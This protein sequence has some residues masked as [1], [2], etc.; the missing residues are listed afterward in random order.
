MIEIDLGVSASGTAQKQD[1]TVLTALP[2]GT[3]VT[4]M[5]TLNSSQSLAST[6][7][8]LTVA[9]DGTISGN[10]DR[11]TNASFGSSTI[12]SGNL[13]FPDPSFGR[14][15]GTLSD[16]VAGAS[17]FSY[18]VV[19]ST[20]LILFSMDAGKLGV[21]QAEKQSGG[22]FNAASFT[23]PYAFASVGDTTVSE[24]TNSAGRFDADGSGAIN[25][26]VLDAV[27][28]GTVA[29]VN[30]TGTYTAATNGRV[31]VSLT[32]GS[33]SI[34]QVYWMVSPS[35]AF[36]ITNSPTSIEDGSV[37]KQVGT[38]ST[39]TLN[40]IYAFG[41]T[42]FDG[43]LTNDLTGTLTGNGSGTLNMVLLPNVNGQIPAQNQTQ[44]FSGTYTVSNNGRVV[45]SLNNFSSNLIMY[46]VSSSQA[47]IIQT[48]S[49]VELHGAMTLQ[50]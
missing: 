26:G 48:D 16:S 15:S 49:N 36:T 6:I 22:P 32:E 7:G 3:F 12:T 37:D 25:N 34:Q 35:R 31:A 10:M 1:T 19:D 2:T 21:G 30:F 18:Y 40:G 9:G 24:G 43:S 45:G 42:G 46:M 5:H 13:N 8:A 29:N 20:H 4:R 23:G 33:N 14:G 11:K 47:Y 50:P 38:F 17:S 28:D 39:A 27:S 44:S 41:I